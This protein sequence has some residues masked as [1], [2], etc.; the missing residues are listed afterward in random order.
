MSLRWIPVLGAIVL[1]GAEAEAQSPLSLWLGAGRS[2]RDSGSVTLRSSD[3]SLGLQLDI[4]MLPLAFRGEASVAASDIVDGPRSWFANAVVPLRL[5]A[6][7]PYL[8]GGYGVY[9]RGTPFETK[10]L[11]Y[12]AGAR[13]G[14]GRLGFFGEV[15]RHD[16]LHRTTGTI[17]ITL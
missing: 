9:S 10:G 12:G 6:V 17:G 14:V 13:I 15:R 16:K 11:N 7:Q 5:P 1:L 3:V 4:P 8:I 2:V